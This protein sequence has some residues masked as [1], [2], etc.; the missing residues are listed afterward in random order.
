VDQEKS[1]SAPIQKSPYHP[2]VI[3]GTSLNALA[4]R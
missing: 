2:A 4:P 3:P 1:L